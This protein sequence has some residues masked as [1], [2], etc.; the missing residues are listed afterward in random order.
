MNKDSIYQ[1]IG[2]QGE[3]N[4]NVKKALKKLLKDNHPD[5][6]GDIKLFKLINEVKRE[7][8]TN[9]VSYKYN[10]ENAKNII[11]DI[12]YDFCKEMILKLEK[13]LT[14]INEKMQTE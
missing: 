9:K 11:N 13:E 3:Y 7:L 1:I 2:Y 6:H 14:I 10:D 4:N 12:D 5:N 8:E